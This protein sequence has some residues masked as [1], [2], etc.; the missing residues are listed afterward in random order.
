MNMFGN[1]IY[2][3]IL[4][5]SVTEVDMDVSD[6]NT[7]DVLSFMNKSHFLSVYTVSVGRLERK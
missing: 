4:L 3:Q 5:K 6:S 7:L 1:A 2:S